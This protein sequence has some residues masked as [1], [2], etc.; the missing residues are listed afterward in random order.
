MNCEQFKEQICVEPNAGREDLLAHERA[1]VSCA[2]WAERARRAEVLI[3]KAVHLNVGERPTALQRGA[4]AQSVAARRMERMGSLAAALV[5]GLAIWFAGAAERPAS[6]EELTSEILAHWDHEA[7]AL[8]VIDESVSAPLLAAVLGD[9][10]HI[11]LAALDRA[12]IGPVTYAKKC[13]VAGQ[14]MSHLVVQSASGPISIM[15]VPE[16]R[17]DAAVPLAAGARGIGGTVVPK[18]D[19]AI[20]ILGDQNAL[21]ATLTDEIAASIEISG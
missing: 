12:A 10:A 19:A 6:T 15:L 2:A 1:C 9:A 18:G 14:W 11:D 16:Q 17:L 13:I 5:A 8:L 20:A 7:A 3:R 21:T 4:Y